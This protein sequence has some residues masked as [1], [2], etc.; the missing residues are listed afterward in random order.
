ML[1]YL[2]FQA[3]LTWIKSTLYSIGTFLFIY[4]LFSVLFGV[5]LYPGILLD[6][7]TD[8]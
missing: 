7:F 5:Y 2:R 6:T 3:Q 1:H 4:L 8:L